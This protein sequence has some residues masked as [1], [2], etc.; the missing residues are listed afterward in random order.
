MGELIVADI[1]G[2]AD[3]DKLTGTNGSDLIE[4]LGGND[5]LAGAAGD[6]TIRGGEGRDFLSGEIGDD[7]L[8]GGAGNDEL[9]GG[10]GADRLFGGNDDDYL[11][12]YEG[13]DQLFGEGGVDRLYI[14]RSGAGTD[15]I[16]ANGG[17]GDDSIGI[18]LSDK[19]SVMI[20]AGA[21][22]DMVS[23]R[24]E[25]IALITLGTGRDTLQFD[26]SNNLGI[27]VVITDFEVGYAGD[28]LD[29]DNYLAATL[30]D[31]EAIIYL[32]Y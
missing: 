19:H 4:G 5:I 18:N 15:A 22:A 28:L 13:S 3:N 26:S 24:S 23:I 21:G 17:D 2:T 7:T 14:S 9:T 8:Q 6:D 27:N 29:W 1:V 16:I 30:T 32:T 12:S 10:A 11:N 20:D 25:S 31:W